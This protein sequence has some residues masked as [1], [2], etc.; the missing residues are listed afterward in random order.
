MATV[1]TGRGRY[2]E[3]GAAT[4][5]ADDVEAGGEGGD[6]HGSG[7]LS[8]CGS[9][10]AISSRISSSWCSAGGGHAAEVP[11]GRAAAGRGEPAGVGDDGALCAG[12]GGVAGD[13]HGAVAPATH[14]SKSIWLLFLGLAGLLVARGY[15]SASLLLPNVPQGDLS[16]VMS[17]VGLGAGTAI[18]LGMIWGAVDVAIYAAR[19]AEAQARRVRLPRFRRRKAEESTLTRRERR[20]TE[21]NGGE[22]RGGN[23]RG[24]AIIRRL[25]LWR[26]GMGGFLGVRNAGGMRVGGV[27]RVREWHFRFLPLFAF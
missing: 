27:S 12:A 24:G 19:Q 22:S 11:A 2:G 6:R 25:A 17:D 4:C 9:C 10:R 16:L 1:A 14:R 5:D 7:L 20:G 15:F 3:V 21:F 26:G 23:G 8:G 13:V 18:V